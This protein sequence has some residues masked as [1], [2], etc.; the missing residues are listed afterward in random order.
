M[1]DKLT[2][3]PDDFY[4]LCILHNVGAT[5]PER[6]LTLEEIARWA[7]MEPSKTEE[8]LSKLIENRYVEVK[9]ILGTKKYFITVDGMR[10]V[11]SMYS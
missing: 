2:S 10:K 8:N 9:E 11:L 6:A 3:M 1:R 7:A 4:V 5:E